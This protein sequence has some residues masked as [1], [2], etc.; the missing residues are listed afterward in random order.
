VEITVRNV[1]DAVV[2]D[3]DG[4][5]MLGEPEKAFLQRTRAVLDTGTRNLAV[6]LKSVPY[7]D[8][9]GVG[10][11]VRVFKWVRERDGNCRFF[12]P[13]K[14]VRQILKMVRLD[15]LLEL[16]DDEDAALAQL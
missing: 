4:P 1:R 11:L 3:L 6:N 14:Q 10:A 9:S 12:A 15:T 5:L 7:M 2:L 16:V 8:S 13:S